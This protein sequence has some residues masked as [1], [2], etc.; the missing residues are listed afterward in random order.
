MFNI[1][2][3]MTITVNAFC[4]SIE[5][6]HSASKHTATNRLQWIETTPSERRDFSTNWTTS[7]SG[8]IAISIT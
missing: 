3:R 4:H 8:P 6:L 5:E 7:S 1:I 2:L